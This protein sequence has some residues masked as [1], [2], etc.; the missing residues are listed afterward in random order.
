MGLTFESHESTEML[1]VPSS[2]T[3]LSP[4][5]QTLREDSFKRSVSE[6]QEL[7]QLFFVDASLTGALSFA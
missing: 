6:Q 2:L 3:R 1:L 5:Q 7:E 4:G